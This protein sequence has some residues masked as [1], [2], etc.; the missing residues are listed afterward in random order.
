MVNYWGYRIDISR[1]DFFREELEKGVLRQGWGYDEGQDLRKEP[2]LVDEGASG[3]LPIYHNVKKGDILLVPRL[4]DWDHVA[5]VEATADFNEGYRFEFSPGEEDYAHMFPARF[6]GKFVRNSELVAGDI[7]S[8]LQ[9][10]GRFWSLNPYSQHIDK[11]LEVARSGNEEKLIKGISFEDRLERVVKES[12]LSFFQK[13]E[14]AEK[15]F[16][17]LLH[18]FQAGEWESLLRHGLAKL[19]P[20]YKVEM[21]GGVS[22]VSHGTDILIRIPGVLADSE[23][24]IA[25]QVRDNYG[26]VDNSAAEKI[27]L[28]DAY[29]EKEGLKIIDHIVLYTKAKREDNLHL[30]QDKRVRYIFGAEF[31]I[32]LTK[33]AKE[34]IGLNENLEI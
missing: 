29:W 32:L 30:T 3:N 5:L 21:T 25:I 2:L 6:V 22:E 17:S 20:S 12:F 23:Y 1:I 15:V 11:L 27:C 26:V 33:I 10:R 8:T 16:E 28:A 7:R 31:K 13:N 34:I 9:Y 18:Q 24:G 4:P 14:F 19:L